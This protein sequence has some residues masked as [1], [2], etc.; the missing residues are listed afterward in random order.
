L[1][2]QRRKREVSA[3]STRRPPIKKE[4]PTRR[5]PVKVEGDKENEQRENFDTTLAECISNPPP[6]MMNNFLPSPE[7]SQDG[8]KY[9]NPYE[10][11]DNHSIAY[12]AAGGYHPLDGQQFYSFPQ[13]ATNAALMCDEDEDDAPADSKVENNMNCSF[14]E[15]YTLLTAP[16]TIPF[17]LGSWRRDETSVF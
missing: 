16:E 2:A 13:Y 15:N 9:Y 4:E 10:Y 3:Q 7:Q 11:M 5:P 14:G 6:P 8:T 17:E 12:A 1:P